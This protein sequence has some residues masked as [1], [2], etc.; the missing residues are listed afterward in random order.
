MVESSFGIGVVVGGLALG[1]WGGFKNKAATSFMGIIGIGA[2]VLLFG[3]APANLFWLGLAGSILLGGMNPIANG[4]FQ[5]IVQSKVA[6]EMQGRVMGATI[7]I[8]TAMM[9]LSMLVVTPVAEFLGIRTWYWA[10]GAL[11][12]LIGACGFFIPSIMGLEKTQKQTA[13]VA[14]AVD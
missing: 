9:P 13:S 12:M 11:T 14:I 7:S 5:A 8:C 4:P 6:P 2:G 10:G 1:V 3:V